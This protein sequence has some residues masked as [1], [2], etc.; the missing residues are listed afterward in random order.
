MNNNRSQSW[1]WVP[2]LYFIEGIPYFIVNSVALLMYKRCGL[3]DEVSALYASWLSLPWVIKPLWSPIVE[4]FKSKQWWI[5]GMEMLMAVA[6]AGVA[7]TLPTPYYVQL[8]MAFFFL[9]AF[10]SATHDIAADGFYMEALDE[11]QQALNVGVRSLFYRLSKVGSEGLLIMFIG[12][13]ETYTRSVFAAWS[14]GLGAV[15]L[16]LALATFYHWAVLPK[17]TTSSENLGTFVRNKAVFDEKQPTFAGKK[18]REQTVREAMTEFVETFVSFFRKPGIMMA[19]TFLLLYRL[20]EALLTKICPLFLTEK[21]SLGGL[22]LSTSEYGFANGVLGVI[23]LLSGGILGGIVVAADGFSKWRWPMVMAIS[24]PNCVYIFLAY[25]QPGNIWWTN[26]AIAIEQFGYG[27][28][29]TLY[30]LFMLF[31]TQGKSK[32]AHYALCTG[33]MAL[34]MMLPG[35]VAGYIATWF[36]YYGSFILVMLL[37]PITFVVT[38]LIRVPDHFGRRVD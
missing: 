19:I 9:I 3:S 25:F 14:L 13:L 17:R 38:S 15:A 2:S 16:L 21:V 20:P 8:T 18:Q 37:V 7:F 29:F 23:G 11:H 32:G 4:I 12:S 1:Q 10:S 34:G 28:G 31:F 36:G 24:L 26:A 6:L 35:Q 22:G 27:F 33:F 30:M 5:V